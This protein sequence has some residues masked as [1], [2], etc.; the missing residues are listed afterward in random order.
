VS[1]M[2][3]EDVF[4]EGVDR[5]ELLAQ[6]CAACQTLRHPPS[7][8][9]AACGSPDWRA[10]KLSGR[11]VILSWIVSRHPNRPELGERVVILVQLE[12]GVRLVS[13]LLDGDNAVVGAPVAV[14][15]GG[16]GDRPLPLFRTRQAG[17]GA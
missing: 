13:N 8:R 11:G 17:A 16:P 1:V 10:E 12:E 5:G 3:D 9:C 4:W 2:R 7:P 15:F 14:E 6:R